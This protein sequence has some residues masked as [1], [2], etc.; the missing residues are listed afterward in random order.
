MTTTS[1]RTGRTLLETIHE[2]WIRLRREGSIYW[3][4][5]TLLVPLTCWIVAVAGVVTVWRALSREPVHGGVLV[6]MLVA[7]PFAVLI[8]GLSMVSLYRAL[9]WLLA[10]DPYEHVPRD[11]R[12]S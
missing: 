10:D 8:G 7:T 5:V 1:P 2:A 3:L 4:V 9:R 11:Q 12:Q 6:A